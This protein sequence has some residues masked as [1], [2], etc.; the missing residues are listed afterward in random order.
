MKEAASVQLPYLGIALTLAVLA[1]ALALIKLPTMTFTKDMRPS[2]LNTGTDDSLLQHPQLLLG[3][4]GIF[5]YVGAEVAIGSFLISYFQLPAIGNLTPRAASLYVSLYWGGAMIGRFIG[6][7]LL[8]RFSTGRVLGLAATVAALLVVTSMLTFGHVAMI[9][10]IAVGLFNSVMFP[11]IF[12]L[13]IAN[14]GPLVGRGS[15][16]MVAAIVGGAL[17]P[18]LEGKIADSSIGLHHA[19]VLPVICYCYIAWFG[20]TRSSAAEGKS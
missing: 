17:I 5:V 7:A 12:T 13:G 6:S 15:S 16:L 10:I 8:Q 19:F 4:L 14:L 11:S 3:A 2:E 18:L 9:T 1:V 20:F